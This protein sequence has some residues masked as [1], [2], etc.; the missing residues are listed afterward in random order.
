MSEIQPGTIAVDWEHRVVYI[1]SFRPD[2]WYDC[3]NPGSGSVLALDSWIEETCEI[4]R[5]VPARG[6]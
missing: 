6:S 4:I 2:R 3:R 5:P 1:R